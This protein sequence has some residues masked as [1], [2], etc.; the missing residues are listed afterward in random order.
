[1][2]R[3]VNEMSQPKD[4]NS[5]YD[6]TEYFDTEEKCLEHLKS[7]RWKEGKY[8]PHCGSLKV[9]EFSNGKT[10]KCGDCRKKFSVKV[11]TIFEDTKIPL[12]KWFMAIYLL[13]SHK[14][15]ISSMQLARDIKITQKSA[16]FILHRLRYASQS[17][18]FRMKLSGDVEVDET[19]LGGKQANKHKSKRESGTPG[20]SMK[21]KSVA[22]GML[23]RG[24][25][26]RM[27]PLDDTK[28]KNIQPVI[29]QNI[30]QGSNIMTDDYK[31]YRGLNKKYNHGVVKHSLKMYV[32]KGNIHTNSVEGALSLFKRGIIGIYHHISRKHLPLYLGEFSYRYNTREFQEDHRIDNFLDRCNGRLTYARLIS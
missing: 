14:K 5:L 19:Y 13:T 10:Y 32:E 28:K 20:R 22:F 1:M 3:G 29:V 4:F 9:Y 15:G 2:I 24:G 26:L 6:L 18:S 12:R 7:V 25:E 30:E 31:S 8:C 17:K 11:G 23:E 27:I 16:W 21:T